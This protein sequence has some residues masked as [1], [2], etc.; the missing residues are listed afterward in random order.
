[1]IVYCQSL[2]FLD[3]KPNSESVSLIGVEC[4]PT[5]AG[6]TGRIGS[7]ESREAFTGKGCFVRE[8]L[9]RRGRIVAVVLLRLA[10]VYH[11]AF[12]HAVT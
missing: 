8:H 11:F 7:F 5:K 6:F 3:N 4:G 12:L 2:Q 1:M 9:A 10:L